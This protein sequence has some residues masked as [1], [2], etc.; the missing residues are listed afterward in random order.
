VFFGEIFL[1]WGKCV[2]SVHGVYEQ[3]LFNDTILHNIAYGRPSATQEQVIQAAK[4]AVIAAFMLCFK[5]IFRLI[6]CVPVEVLEHDVVQKFSSDLC[7]P[8]VFVQQRLHDAVL[9]MPDGYATRVGERGLK[10]RV[11]L[12]QK[13]IK[14][15]RNNE[16]VQNHFIVY[17]P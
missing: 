1:Q 6:V 4:Q 8:P 5:S 2:I 12:G 16:P 10:V 7:F 14:D 15:E 3:V 9:R 13:N 17:L 11:P